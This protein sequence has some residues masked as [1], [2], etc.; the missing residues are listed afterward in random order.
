[1]AVGHATSGRLIAVEGT[2]GP[3]LAAAAKHL[4]RGLGDGASGVSAWDASGI[5]TELAAAEPQVA[6]PTTRTLTLL[7]AA[8]LAFRLRWQIRP[9]LDAGH[10][11][12]AAPYVQSAMALGSAAG[13]PTRWLIE[14]F[15]FA[16]AP[17]VCYRVRERRLRSSVQA[18][19][20]YLEFF[21]GAIDAG[22]DPRQSARLRTRAIDFLDRLERRRRC[23][24]LTARASRPWH[25][26]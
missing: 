1:M 4:S 24:P 15:R 6:R 10:A 2:C 14:L 3:D 13:L 16:P 17:H 23:T 22:G 9:A 25:L 5:F 18:A 21:C 11:V 12:V 19:S 26:R 20:G 7:Y 8:D